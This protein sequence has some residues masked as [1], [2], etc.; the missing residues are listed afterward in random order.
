MAKS[1]LVD[2]TRC[3]GCRGCQAACKE[4]N[5]RS[6]RKTS[7]HGDYANPVRLNSDT[8]TRIR[9][10]EKEGKD[11]PVWSFIKEQCLHCISP[12][13]TSVCP[14]SALTKSDDGPVVY[15]YDRCIG[16]RYCMLACPFRIPTFEW[17]SAQP[18]V[19]KCSFCSERIKDG[20]IPA[21]IKVCPTTTMFYGEYKEVLAEAKRRIADN[22]GKY[23]NHIYGE[24]EAGGT[25]WM[26]ISNV[27]FEELGFRENVPQFMLP[28][29]TWSYIKK[30]PALFGVVLVAGAGAWV[31]TRR[32][33]AE[34]KEGQR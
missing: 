8:Y 2:L 27:P 7:F 15:N 26:Y 16:C 19:Q 32:N 28:N 22:P 29:L 20:L 23:F 17:E 11:R 14:V 5:E 21:C 13:C 18:W 4:W 31:I 1:V 30:V 6:A 3:I 24:H 34:H 25:S 9:F 10:S 33:E 12:A